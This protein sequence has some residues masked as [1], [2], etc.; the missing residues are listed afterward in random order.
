MHLRGTRRRSN[1]QRGSK[2]DWVADF[3]T[4]TDPLD[5][6]V[7][8]WGIKDIF[9]EDTFEYG[10]SMGG[11]VTRLSRMNARVYFHNL[12]FDGRFILDWLLKDGFTHRTG[13]RVRLRNKE[14][15]SLISGDGKFYSISVRW[16]T[17]CT[18]EFRDSLKKLPMS[19]ARVAK[20][21]NME[22]AKG[23]IDYDAPR[24]VTY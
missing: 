6:R 23:H 19:V 9:D 1:G 17:G 16:Q 12:G 18:T 5:C 2:S 11:F 14:F 15:S 8:A 20:S 22:I 7:W 13:E 4:T 3:E 21:F 24:P 10:T